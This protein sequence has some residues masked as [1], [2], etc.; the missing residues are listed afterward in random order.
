MESRN[1]KRAACGIPRLSCGH[2]CRG[3]APRRVQLAP[4]MLDVEALPGLM[5]IDSTRSEDSGCAAER[6]L[7]PGRASQLSMSSAHS[8]ERVPAAQVGSKCGDS[9][10]DATVELSGAADDRIAPSVPHHGPLFAPRPRQPHFCSYAAEVFCKIA[11][12]RFPGA[13]LRR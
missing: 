5:D 13:Q 10:H 7:L 2:G 6:L 4:R 12:I 11:R 8:A 1:T 3:A 9:N